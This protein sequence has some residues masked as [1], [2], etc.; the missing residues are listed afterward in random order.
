MCLAGLVQGPAACGGGRARGRDQAASAAQSTLRGGQLQGMPAGRVVTCKIA[1]LL[2]GSSEAA[3][4][5]LAVRRLSWRHSARWP[6]GTPSECAAHQAACMSFSRGCVAHRAP[7]GWS[8]CLA[9]SRVRELVEGGLPVGCSQGSAPHDTLLHWAACFGHERV[10]EVLIG[11]GAQVNALNDEVRR[12]ASPQ[13]RRRAGRRGWQRLTDDCF[14]VPQGVTPLHEAAR[15][16]QIRSV[17]TAPLLGDSSVDGG[18]CPR[19]DE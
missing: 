7:C 2:L 8:V 9:G 17:S 3:S 5:S 18:Y 1:C 6:P 13:S 12:G 4:V 11:L 14:A 19:V 15:N 16:G 10:V